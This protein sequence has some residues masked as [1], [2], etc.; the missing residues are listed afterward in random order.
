[1]AKILQVGVNISCNIKEINKLN[2]REVGL[3][4]TNQ[5]IAVNPVGCFISLLRLF[6]QL[7]IMIIHI[8][9]T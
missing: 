7:E 9:K 2:R 8:T 3:G 6:Q 5:K 4:I 1:M